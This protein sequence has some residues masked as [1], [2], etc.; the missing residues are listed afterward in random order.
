ML[1]EKA[2]DPKTQ[3][4]KGH[5]FFICINPVKN[6]GPCLN[7]NGGRWSV[8]ADMPGEGKDA[9]RHEKEVGKPVRF[10]RSATKKA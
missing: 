5:L 8:V 10:R 7:Q 3:P 2:T 6:G 4:I 9:K 1:V